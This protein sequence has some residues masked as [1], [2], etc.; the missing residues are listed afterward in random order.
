MIEPDG[1]EVIDEEFSSF[2][3]IVEDGTRPGLFTFLI[4]EL[5][6]LAVGDEIGTVAR[7]R[8]GADGR[9][10]FGL[11]TLG[12]E[13]GFDVGTGEGE[14]EEAV[15]GI[16]AAFGVAG[17]VGVAPLRRQVEMGERPGG[18]VSVRLQ[19][20]HLLGDGEVGSFHAG[21]FSGNGDEARLARMPLVF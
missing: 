13:A 11:K 3:E 12:G 6:F 15:H 8:L 7:V 9:Q 4:V 20:L 17:L 18:H 14:G 19:R 2:C 16:L 5:P 10:V 1:E 21:D